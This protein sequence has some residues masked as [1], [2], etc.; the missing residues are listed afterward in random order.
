MQ[1]YTKYK[2]INILIQIIFDDKNVHAKQKNLG[3][4]V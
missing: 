1:L 2:K 3:Y 4:K